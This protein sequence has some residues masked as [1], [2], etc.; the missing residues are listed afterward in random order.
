MAKPTFVHGIGVGDTATNTATSQ[1]FTTGVGETYMLVFSYSRVGGTAATISSVVFGATTLSQLITL[2]D[3][4]SSIRGYIHGAI[5]PAST[6][7]NVVVTWAGTNSNAVVGICG[8]SGVT[9]VG[10]P[11]S[12]VKEPGTGQG[13]VGPTIVV[14]GDTLAVGACGNAQAD[15]MTKDASLSA[16]IALFQDGA[17]VVEEETTSGSTAA[18]VVQ[19]T[20][21]PTNDSAIVLAIPLLGTASASG[22][23]QVVARYHRY[24]FGG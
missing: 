22:N 23:P 7:A 10:T 20:G 11:Q 12:A 13:A 18:G 19:W 21:N 16:I 1:S 6:T 5:V 24:H 2:A 15:T 17:S 9:S 14:S 3:S 4:N 8:F